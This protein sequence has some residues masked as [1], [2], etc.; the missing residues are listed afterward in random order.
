MVHL[1]IESAHPEI[2]VGTMPGAGGTQRLPLA[3]GKHKAMDLLLSGRMM[4]A[5]EAELAGLVSRIVPREEL[6][7]TARSVAQT[8]A[9]YSRP[10]LKLLKQSILQAHA[11]PLSEGLSFERK[12]FQ[13]TF[14]FEDRKEGMEAFIEKRKPHF[15]DR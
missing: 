9:S 10:V 5:K 4:N 8:V 1:Q 13:M 14:G 7:E 15:M 11:T 12:L 3:I 2:S 6:L